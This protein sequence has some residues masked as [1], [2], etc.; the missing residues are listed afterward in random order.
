[1]KAKDIIDFIT[2]LYFVLSPIVIVVLITKYRHYKEHF[3]LEVKQ[4]NMY[5]ELY[6]TEH[7]YAKGLEELLKKK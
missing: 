1:M 7:K 4:S 5:S 3:E 2:I 6:E